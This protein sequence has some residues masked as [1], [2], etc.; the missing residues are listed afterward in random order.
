ML[1]ANWMPLVFGLASALLTWYV[2][3]S[4]RQHPFIADEAAYVLQ[5]KIFARGSWTAPAPPLPEFFE[6][7]YVLLR[8]AIAAKSLN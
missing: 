4:L 6:Q 5:S 7:S 2:W 1:D 8:P 3:G